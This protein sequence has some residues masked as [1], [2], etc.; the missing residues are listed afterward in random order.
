[1]LTSVDG[2]G[3][4]C[5]AVNDE[6]SSRRGRKQRQS[7]KRT[8][9]AQVSRCCRTVITPPPNLSPIGI[10]IASPLGTFLSHRRIWSA[11]MT[12]CSRSSL[13]NHYL[14]QRM[15]TIDIDILV[16]YLY[17]RCKP[18]GCFHENGSC[19]VATVVATPE[20]MY[21]GFLTQGKHSRYSILL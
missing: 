16:L 1:M 6:H 17:I 3:P 18:V 8:E 10:E 20:E 14:D 2:T 13:P 4:D 9:E 5:P 11:V 12:S 15:P 19:H 21:A 7:D